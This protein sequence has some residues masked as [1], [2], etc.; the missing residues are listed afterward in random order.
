MLCKAQEILDHNLLMGEANIKLFHICI[1][2][3]RL[4]LQHNLPSSKSKTGRVRDKLRRLAGFDGV[5]S[6][7][8]PLLARNHSAFMKALQPN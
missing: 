8:L 5:S 3:C 4:V 2:P 6:G 7:A 1:D